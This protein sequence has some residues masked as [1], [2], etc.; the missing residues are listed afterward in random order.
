MAAVAALAPACAGTGTPVPMPPRELPPLDLPTSPP[1]D[2]H[3]RV[4]LDVVDGPTIVHVIEGQASA[5]SHQTGGT[6]SAVYERRLCQTP[7]AV[8]LPF[9]EHE[10]RLSLDH[11]H[12]RGGH[13]LV[14]VRGPATALRARLGHRT[15]GGPIAF[16]GALLIFGGAPTSI[17][18][19]ILWGITSGDGSD[20]AEQARTATLWGLGA[21]A[22]GT[23]LYLLDRPVF[24]PSSSTQWRL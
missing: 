6:A 4:V 3:G 1:P 22:V 23:V 13:E 16:A 10:I 12:N 2:G 7:C 5:V 8:D 18:S 17:G 11:D 24:H 15:G 14:D 9:G 21:L 20:D 19:A